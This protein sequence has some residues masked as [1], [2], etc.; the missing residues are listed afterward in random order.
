MERV[1][2]TEKT[3]FL[4]YRRTNISWALAI[5]QNLTQ[6]GFDV[7][8][9][10]NGIAG[11]DFERVML[12]SIRARAHFLVF[13]TPST[14]ERCADPDDWLRREIEIA[15]DSHRNIVPLMLEGFDLGT[16]TIVAQLTG[17]LA[18]LRHYNAL[19][20][21]AAYF[22]GSMERLRRGFLE[23]PIIPEVF[24]PYLFHY[25][26]KPQ[27]KRPRLTLALSYVSALVSSVS[28]PKTKNLYNVFMR[29][30]HRTMLNAGSRRM[31]S[32]VAKRFTSKLTEPS[33][34]WTAYC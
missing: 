19:H 29:T 5:Y 20:I 8:F 16:P 7:F 3:V 6:H 18:A 15:L 24:P 9:D 27:H 31:T 21:S 25:S 32:G 2:K 12:E 34:S 28:R 26:E 14:L 13:L 33:S 22:S 1:K 11:G 30:L 4:S 10:F 17:K 23:V